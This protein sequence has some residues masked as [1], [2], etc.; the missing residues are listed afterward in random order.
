MSHVLVA[1]SFINNDND[2]DPHHHYQPLQST[3]AKSGSTCTILPI[4]KYEHAPAPRACSSSKSMQHTIEYEKITAHINFSLHSRTK[5]FV[6]ACIYLG[7]CMCT[8]ELTAVS[9][10]PVTMSW[11]RLASRNVM[12][13]T[14]FVEI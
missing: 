6:I 14:L 12:V 11:S 5:I 4:V 1:S 10:F 13:I 8:S 3:H 2:D 9:D 7:D